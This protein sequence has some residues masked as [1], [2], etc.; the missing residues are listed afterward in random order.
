MTKE[1]C[2]ILND[3]IVV[4]Y[5]LNDIENIT[6]HIAKDI[7]SESDIKGNGISSNDVVIVI[8]FKDNTESTFVATKCEMKFL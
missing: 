7:Y 4:Y 6:Y 8:L 3:E 1:L 2:I 5:N